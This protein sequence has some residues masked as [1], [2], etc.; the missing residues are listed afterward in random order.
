VFYSYILKLSNN[1]YYAGYTEDLR[2]RLKYHQDGLV[3]ATKN[4]RPVKL[5]FYAAFSTQKL[6]TDFE[7]YLKTSSGFAFRNKRLVK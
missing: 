1:E 7:K 4:F 3:V 5:T 2:Q 6:A